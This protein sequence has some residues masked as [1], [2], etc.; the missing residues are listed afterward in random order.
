MYAED[1]NQ[2]EWSIDMLLSDT[3][4]EDFSNKNL[5]WSDDSLILVSPSWWDH[6]IALETI[7]SSISWADNQSE[8]SWE[9]LWTPLPIDKEYEEDNTSHEQQIDDVS[10]HNDKIVVSTSSASIVSDT[11]QRTVVVDN[12]IVTIIWK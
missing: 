1:N 3:R 7:T 11:E 12:D 4:V 9:F 10:L 2:I 8:L 5:S 6:T